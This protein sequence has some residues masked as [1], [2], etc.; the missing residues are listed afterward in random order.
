MPLSKGGGCKV[1]SHNF[2]RRRQTTLESARSTSCIVYLSSRNRGPTNLISDPLCTEP[3]SFS[4]SIAMLY[5]ATVTMQASKLNQLSSRVSLVVDDP[6]HPGYGRAP[7]A[8]RSS[9]SR[10]LSHSALAW[11]AGTHGHQKSGDERASF[12]PHSPQHVPLTKD[13]R[14][15]HKPQLR[16]RDQQ[17]L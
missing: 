16:R 2:P 11:L 7:T 13:G 8:H 12:S 5:D 10:W 6:R 4:R 9:C 17:D 14:T 15:Q 3:C 1:G